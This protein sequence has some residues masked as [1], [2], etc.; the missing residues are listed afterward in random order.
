[1]DDL[2]QCRKIVC[3]SCGSRLTFAPLCLF[4]RCLWCG[5]RPQ[6]NSDESGT[7]GTQNQLRTRRCL[8][9]QPLQRLVR[10]PPH[11][12]EVVTWP[13][14]WKALFPRFFYSSAEIFVDLYHLRFQIQFAADIGDLYRHC[15]DLTHILRR[16][17]V[18]QGLEKRFLC[19]GIDIRGLRPAA[20]CFCSC[21]FVTGNQ[22]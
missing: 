15:E 6:A 12:G 20:T 2:I 21:N 1:M 18:N 7:P 22:K 11:M 3:L 17:S 16:F 14:G 4:R 13:C 5:R 9:Q 10:R 19:G 8:V